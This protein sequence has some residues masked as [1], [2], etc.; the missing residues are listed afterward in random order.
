MS[1]YL[2]SVGFPWGHV[3]VALGLDNSDGWITLE[4]TSLYN[5][6][7]LNDRFTQ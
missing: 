2:M 6:S 3:R 5:L 7:G 4:V 1:H